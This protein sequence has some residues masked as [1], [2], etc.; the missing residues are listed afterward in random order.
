MQVHECCSASST[1]LVCMVDVHRNTAS[2]LQFKFTTISISAI[3]FLLAIFQF[4]ASWRPPAWP[5][6]SPSGHSPRGEKFNFSL[7]VFKE[8][9]KAHRHRP[10]NGIAKRLLHHFQMAYYVT[11]NGISF[12]G[13]IKNVVRRE[14]VCR[15]CL[16]QCGIHAT[17]TQFH[18]R[19]TL[20][21]ACCNGICGFLAD[22]HT[23]TMYTG[24][25]TY[26]CK[27]VPIIKYTCTYLM[28]YRTVLCG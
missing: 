7:V 16:W 11:S 23:R 22:D 20:F 21:Y 8:E 13:R 17:A 18:L 27:C 5:L 9:E 12:N 3:L 2:Q 14:E 6:S 4:L 10:A 24:V 15:C 19:Y 1:V 25:S 26:K 28:V